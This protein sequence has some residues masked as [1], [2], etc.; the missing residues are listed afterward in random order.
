M[1][2][3]SS[4]RE[5]ELPRSSMMNNR[6]AGLQD[7]APDVAHDWA[8][9]QVSRSLDLVAAARIVQGQLCIWHADYRLAS[10]IS[11]AQDAMLGLLE[12]HVLHWRLDHSAIG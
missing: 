10:S 7:T 4:P 5:R 6:L 8:S 11:N 9:Q 2:D 3:C 12:G 1:L